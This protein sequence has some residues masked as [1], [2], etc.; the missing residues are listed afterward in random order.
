MA[1]F[2]LHFSESLLDEVNVL[3][4]LEEKVKSFEKMVNLWIKSSLQYLTKARNES[5]NSKHANTSARPTTPVT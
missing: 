1:F 2:T 4:F 3:S 5:R